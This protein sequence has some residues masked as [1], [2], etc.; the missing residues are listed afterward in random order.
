MLPFLQVSPLNDID[1]ILDCETRPTVADD[2][3]ASKLGSKQVFVKQY[4]VKWKGL[5]YLH[6][7]WYFY[8]KTTTLFALDSLYIYESCTATK[9]IF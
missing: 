1:K 2:N 8:F 5:S 7:T 6:C 4:L 9:G 3:D